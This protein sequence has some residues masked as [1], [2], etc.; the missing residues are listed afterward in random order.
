MVFEIIL[1]ILAAI[2][3]LIA[4][5][6]SLPLHIYIKTDKDEKFS[7]KVKILFFNLTKKRKEKKE[8]PAPKDEKPKSTAEKVL[9][10]FGFS[11]FSSLRSI[12]ERLQKSGVATTVSELGKLVVDL[13]KRAAGLVKHIKL[14][15]LNVKVVCASD[16][17]AAAAI[18]YGA[19]CAILYPAVSFISSSVKTKTNALNVNVSCGYDDCE[20]DLYVD[21]HFSIRMFFLVKAVIKITFDNFKKEFKNGR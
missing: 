17:A 21:T 7:A 2:A 15:R 6:L 14:H 16:D 20:S 5:V 9:S 3:V 1:L 11:D 19:V 4:L 18:E 12:K 10:F 8:P 13:I